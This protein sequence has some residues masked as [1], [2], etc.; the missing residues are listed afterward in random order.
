MY[1][2]VEDAGAGETGKIKLMDGERTVSWIEYEVISESGHVMGDDTT[3]HL[4]ATFTVKGEEGKGYASRVVEESLKYAGKFGKVKISC[5]Y[6]K[7][8][9]EKHG[10]SGSIE[11]TN[12][13]KFK[14]SIDKFN[15]YHSPEAVAEYVR[16]EKDRV[17]VKFYGPFCLSCG[18]YD[19]FEDILPDL[20]D[21]GIGAEVQN[22]EKLDGEDG[23]L[24]IYRVIEGDLI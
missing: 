17:Y 15:K 13:L 24:V 1:I 5:P 8:W 16:Y 20:E 18:I 21:A 9:I 12:L 23:F 10:Y 11:F 6:I 22:Y 14:E 3:I 4:I 19:Y 7:K 2:R